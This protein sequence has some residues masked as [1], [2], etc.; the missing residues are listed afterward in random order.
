MLYAPLVASA[1]GCFV[2]CWHCVQVDILMS[3]VSGS[4]I[5]LGQTSPR[6]AACKALQIGQSLNQTAI[7]LLALT[8]SGPIEPVRSRDQ[9]AQK[10]FGGSIDLLA[11]C[12]SVLQARQEPG[13][14]QRAG[15]IHVLQT[16]ICSSEE[17]LDMRQC[18][19]VI[20]Q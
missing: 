5:C 4:V 13:A 7:V 8:Q 11:S 19:L 6:L 15:R 2:L 10:K 1:V 18:R 9:T 17:R 16:L 20:V 3:T 14:A 12:K